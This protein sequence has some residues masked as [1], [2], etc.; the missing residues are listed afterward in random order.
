MAKFIELTQFII[1]KTVKVTINVEHILRIEQDCQS[2]G[3][4]IYW[5]LPPSNDRGAM[6]PEVFQESYDEVL[7]LIE[8]KE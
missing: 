8:S 5:A 4:L 6:I 7:R 1:N 3:S 2:N